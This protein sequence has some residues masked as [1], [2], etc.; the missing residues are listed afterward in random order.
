MYADCLGLCGDLSGD[1]LI[2][3]IRQCLCDLT[4]GAFEWCDE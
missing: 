1:A 4:N 2:A 3:C